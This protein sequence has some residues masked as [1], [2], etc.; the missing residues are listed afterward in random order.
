MV[1]PLLSSCQ[2]VQAAPPHKHTHRA[3]ANQLKITCYFRLMG[4]FPNNCM[5]P[6]RKFG[7]IRI[8]GLIRMKEESPL[9]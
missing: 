6:A 7:R 8:L 1:A 3:T 5:I 9:M 4:V 2:G